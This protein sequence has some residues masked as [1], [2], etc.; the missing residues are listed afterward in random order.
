MHSVCVPT[1]VNLPWQYNWFNKFPSSVGKWRKIKPYYSIW[2]QNID[3]KFLLS[4]KLP[5]N[6]IKIKQ[7]KWNHST[8]SPDI[9]LRF[10]CVDEL[11]KSVEGRGWMHQGWIFKYYSL[12]LWFGALC[13]F[14]KLHIRFLFCC[15]L[16]GYTHTPPPAVA[17][18]VPDQHYFSMIISRMKIYF[19]IA[20]ICIYIM[21][22]S[23]TQIL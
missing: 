4:G 17:Q 20:R 13:I 22:R 8:S 18:P 6:Y 15:K 2:E 1:I 3:E 5:N 21:V 11:Q 12:L 23:Y 9:R 7:E 16:Y 10:R 19:R 14:H